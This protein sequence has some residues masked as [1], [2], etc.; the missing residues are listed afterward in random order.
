VAGR[1]AEATPPAAPQPAPPTVP[2][3]AP[4]A[5]PP[6]ARPPEPAPSPAPAPAAAVA[7]APEPVAERPVTPPPPDPARD[8]A[9]IRGVLAQYVAGYQR[10]EF[11]ALRR[12]WPSAPASLQQSFAEYRS[13]D[14]VLESPQITI[15]GDTATV[16]SMRRIRVQP[17]AGR[18]QEASGQMTLALR[19]AG[20]AWVI[21]SVK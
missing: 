12:V 14:I 5:T 2:T 13:Y 9:A 3:D 17:R 7:R 18:A 21:D 10:L 6:A 8:E 16:S 15:R 11:A 4:T 1:G 19:R 20:N